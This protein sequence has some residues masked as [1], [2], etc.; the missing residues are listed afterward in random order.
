MDPQGNDRGKMLFS[1]AGLLLARM[2]QT[3]VVTSDR[4]YPGSVETVRIVQLDPK[5]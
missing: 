5:R 3:R 2:E 4:I 1:K